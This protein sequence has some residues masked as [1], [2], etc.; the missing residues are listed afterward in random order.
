MEI[1]EKVEKNDCDELLATITTKG[2]TNSIVFLAAQYG[3]EVPAKSTKE[4]GGMDGG[5]LVPSVV[6]STQGM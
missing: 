4:S 3:N 5:L 2:L 1:K 6:Y